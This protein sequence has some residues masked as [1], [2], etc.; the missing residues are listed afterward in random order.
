[1]RVSSTREILHREVNQAIHV[2]KTGFF[3]HFAADRHEHL[4]HQQ[5]N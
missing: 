5:L 3:V 4:A 2:R 1:M